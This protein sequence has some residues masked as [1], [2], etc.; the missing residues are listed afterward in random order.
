[1]HICA[2]EHDCSTAEAQASQIHKRKRKQQSRNAS[3]RSQIVI[4]EPQNTANPPSPPTCS[5][6]GPSATRGA[7]LALNLGAG[8]SGTW[9]G[10]RPQS[11]RALKNADIHTYED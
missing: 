3:T 5:R 9:G 7:R 1:M 8:G 10:L 4:N 11:M 2:L 6:V